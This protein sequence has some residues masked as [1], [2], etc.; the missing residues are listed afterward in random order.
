MPL[1]LVYAVDDRIEIMHI[2]NKLFSQTIKEH[3]TLKRIKLTHP[4]VL[5]LKALNIRSLQSEQNK[6]RNI[7]C[8]NANEA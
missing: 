1:K 4:P 3:V 5:W 8:N 2:L 6:L 7:H